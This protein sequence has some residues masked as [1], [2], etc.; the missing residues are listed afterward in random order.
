MPKIRRHPTNLPERKPSGASIL[1]RAVPVEQLEDPHIH[2]LLYGRN[3]AGKT[4]LACQFPK[5]LLLVAVEPSKTGGA[6][7]VR[8]VEGVQV[9][10]L[11]ESD[12]VELLGRELVAQC[13]FATVVPD[14]ASSLDEMV[15]ADICGWSQTANMLRWGKV[16]QDQ[17]TERSE[18]MRKILRNYL[19]LEAHV[20][21]IANEKDHNPPEGKRNPMVRGIQDESF[22]AAAMGGGTA[23]WLQD[24]C[25]YIAQLYVD[26]ETKRVTRKVA[27]KE[28]TSQ[29]ETGRFIRKLRCGYHPNFAVRFRSETPEEVP[30]AIVEP[31]FEKIQ[32]VIG[33]EG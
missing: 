7:S 5:P 18:R 31:T 25:D 32:A 2:M 17:Y 16:T 28:V 23:R 20:V 14:S 22:F 24:S 4:T 8:R 10:R 12:D 9:V 29:E 15:L 30:D 19:E 27:G 33:G 21:I 26:R 6:R 1:S 3:G 13:E 11:L